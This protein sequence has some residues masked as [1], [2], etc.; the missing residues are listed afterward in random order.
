VP[1]GT[2]GRD[3][4]GGRTRITAGRDIAREER[5][6]QCRSNN[7]HQYLI[8]SQVGINF[9]LSI[10]TGPR[11]RHALQLPER[12]TPIASVR[13]GSMPHAIRSGANEQ[14]HVDLLLQTCPNQPIASDTPIVD[15]AY[16]AFRDL[17]SLSDIG[18]VGKARRKRF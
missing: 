14:P 10:A 5:T 3:H 12:Q 6:G 13:L 1:V 9:N 16:S 7:K 18:A 4:A 2:R 15:F 17:R 8:S 11:R